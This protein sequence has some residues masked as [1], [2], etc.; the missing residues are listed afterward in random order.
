MRAIKYSMRNEFIILFLSLLPYDWRQRINFDFLDSMDPHW[1]KRFAIEF[2]TKRNGQGKVMDKLRDI[3]RRRQSQSLKSSTSFDAV[4]A[5]LITIDKNSRRE[6]LLA[7]FLFR[8]ARTIRQYA[9]TIEYAS[10]LLQKTQIH[11]LLDRLYE[12][13]TKEGV[14]T[15]A[16]QAEMLIFLQKTYNVPSF[17]EK[18]CKIKEQWDLCLEATPIIPAARNIYD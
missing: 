16:Y 15:F 10:M 3:F 11:K 12:A 13:V 7:D 2:R 18:R 17:E 9:D 1:W 6:T 4:V 5:E 14:D 8:N